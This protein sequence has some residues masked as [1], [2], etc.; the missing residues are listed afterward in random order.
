MNELLFVGWVY[1]DAGA[2]EFCFNVQSKSKAIS[3]DMGSSIR[4]EGQVKVLAS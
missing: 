2:F 1:I 3:L 4:P